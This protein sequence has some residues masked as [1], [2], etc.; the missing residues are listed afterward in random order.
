LKLNLLPRHN[1]FLAQ[2]SADIATIS[3]VE[4]EKDITTL[5]IALAYA[6]IL[7]VQVLTLEQLGIT[8]PIERFGA[9][10]DGEIGREEVFYGCDNTLTD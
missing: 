2:Q 3:S 5:L 9:Y 6:E 8:I 1:Y 7:G 4:L 10:L